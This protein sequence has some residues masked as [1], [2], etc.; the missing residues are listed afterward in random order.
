[1]RNHILFSFFLLLC[2]IVIPVHAQSD[3][4]FNQVD[5]QGMKQGYWKKYYPNGNLMYKG[6]LRDNKPVGEMRRYY[7]SGGIKVVMIFD[8]S[9]DYSRSTLYYESGEL[10]ARGNYVG[11]EKDS[12]WEYYSYYDHSIKARETYTKGRRNGFAYHYFPDGTISEKL[13][14]KDNMKH[15]TWEQ[16]YANKAIM[17]RGSYKDDKLNGPFFVTNENGVLSVKGIFL[18]NLRHDKWVFYK[19]DG[20]IDVEVNYNHG[21]PSGEDLLTEK[22]KEILRMVDENQGK[23][24][25]PDETDFLQRGN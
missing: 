12:T 19:E 21:N 3:T 13:E 17:I 22:Q 23:F 9:K 14:W 25:E 5:A 1:M 18:D 8:G 2:G 11:M 7:E 16:Y 24:N 20:T 6:F 10:A 15:G 4:L